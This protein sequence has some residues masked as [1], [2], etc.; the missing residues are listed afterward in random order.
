MKLLTST[1]NK[2]TIDKNSEN[3]P[4]LEITKVVLVHCNIVNNEYQQ[5]SRDLHTFIPIKSFDKLLDTSQKV[6][7]LER[8]LIQRF[9]LLKHNLLIKTPNPER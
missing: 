1:N 7:Y 8:H 4:H 2:I 5:N 3:V 9:R 6:S